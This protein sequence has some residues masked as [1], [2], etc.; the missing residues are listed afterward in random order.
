MARTTALAPPA[1][2]TARLREKARCSSVRQPCACRVASAGKARIAAMACGKGRGGRVVSKC[3][4]HK[5][6]AAQLGLGWLGLA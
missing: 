1:S 5:A 3:E 6:G 2:H 4:M